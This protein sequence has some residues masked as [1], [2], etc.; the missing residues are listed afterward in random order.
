MASR[1][2]RLITR[3]STKNPVLLP[4]VGNRLR[5]RPGHKRD[6]KESGV[7]ESIGML[8]VTPVLSARSDW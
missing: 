8:L 4:V 7:L 3:N 2:S 1:S 6:G 5:R